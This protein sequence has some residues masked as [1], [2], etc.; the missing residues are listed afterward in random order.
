M[1]L[2][3]DNLFG[4]DSAENEFFEN[5]NDES[6]RGKYV[7]KVVDTAIA[8]TLE[9]HGLNL[10]SSSS[11]NPGGGMQITTKSN[12]LKLRQ[13]IKHASCTAKSAVLLDSSFAVL[14][15]GNFNLDSF[16]YILEPNTVY[17]VGVP[18]GIYTRRYTGAGTPVAGTNVDW[19]AG[20]Y[21]GAVSSPHNIIQIVT[22]IYDSYPV[23][24]SELY[25]N[26]SEQELYN[27]QFNLGV[28]GTAALDM[29]IKFNA[30][31]D[32]TGKY[33]ITTFPAMGV[34]TNPVSLGTESVLPT[35]A[36]ELFYIV[37]GY[38]NNLNNAGKIELSIAPNS[39]TVG[40]VTLN[41]GSWATLDKK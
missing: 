40:T 36:A 23:N 31:V 3:T 11:V 34:S 4:T 38:V 29:K 22:E 5:Y 37:N 28:I 35:D 26:I 10:S 19:T 16:S 7:A 15:S 20:Y 21:N 27:F 25:F 33:W 1:G 13:I 2:D 24:D 12:R 30:P 32:A 39:P 6:V 41:T 17:Y 8:I 9:S 14:A 18:D